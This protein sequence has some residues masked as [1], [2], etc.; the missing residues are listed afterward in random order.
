MDNNR[1][2]TQADKILEFH[3]FQ[4][5]VSN[6]EVDIY[7]CKRPDCSTYMFEIII[8]KNHIITTGDLKPALVFKITGGI[9]SLAES[10][11]DYVCKKLE[12]IYR[13]KRELNVEYFEKWL[14]KFMLEDLIKNDYEIPEFW[15]YDKLCFQDMVDL[16]ETK[17]NY[18]QHCGYRA[19][20]EWIGIDSD[21]S[22][23]K[24]YEILQHYDD[25]PSKHTSVSRIDSDVK[26]A[27]YVVYEAARRII[28]MEKKE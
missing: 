17:G 4:K 27:S 10:E 23:E 14:K 9:T 26:L 18:N 3:K 7:R 6:E 5:I 25:D 8:T 13:E 21:Q 24:A 28:E 22:L 16:Y 1:I 20:E 19:F 12:P 2:K 11:F 15:D